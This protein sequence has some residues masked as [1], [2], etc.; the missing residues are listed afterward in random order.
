M[1]DI[2][3]VHLSTKNYSLT[4]CSFEKCFHDYSLLFSHHP[5]PDVLEQLIAIHLVTW[6]GKVSQLHSQLH[7]NQRARG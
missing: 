5:Q 7:R 2:Q 6:V 1:D 4:Q 3:S